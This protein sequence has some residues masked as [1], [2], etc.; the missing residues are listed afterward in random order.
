MGS[1]DQRRRRGRLLHGMVDVVVVGRRRQIRQSNPRLIT[2]ARVRFN[3]NHHR[4]R[5]VARA[6]L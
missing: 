4:R 1:I 2:I 3:L 5:R 6:V